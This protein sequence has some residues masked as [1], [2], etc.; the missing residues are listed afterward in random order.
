MTQHTPK[1]IPTRFW[2]MAFIAFLLA[3]PVTFIG[4]L[5]G[6]AAG[7]AIAILSLVFFFVVLYMLVVRKYLS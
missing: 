5:M 3:G 6:G 7:G 2:V 4:F 1:K